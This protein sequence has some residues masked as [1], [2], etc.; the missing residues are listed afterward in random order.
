MKT[1]IQIEIQPFPVPGHVDEAK[2][3]AA[4]YQ[5]KDPCDYQ[6]AFRTFALCE[7]SADDMRKLCDDFT[8]SVFKAA[9]KNQ[10]PRPM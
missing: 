9:G 5:E 7:L 3:F 2:A 8:K 6:P 4:V 10:P 1:E